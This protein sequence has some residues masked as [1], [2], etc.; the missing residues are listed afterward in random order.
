M[1]NYGVLK[2]RAQKF[3]RDND[4]DPH[5]ELLVDGGGTMYRIAVNVRSSRGPAATRLVEYLI[6][7]NV[8]HVIVEQA[9]LLPIGWSDLRDGVDDAAA[10]D[11]I[12]SNIFRANQMV[13][14][15]HDKPGPGNDLFEKLEDLFER[16]IE[17]AAAVVYAFGERWGPET[18]PDDYFG[19]V[20][21]NG[22]HDIHM[23]QGDSREQNAR[24][25]DGALLVEFPGAQITTG[26]FIKFQTQAWHTDENTGDPLPG[27]P[28]V[29]P[30]VVP[31]QGPIK[32]WDPVP[33]DSPYRV[34]RIVGAW[35]SP[36][37]DDLGKESVTVCNTSSRPLIVDGWSILD[38][39]DNAERISGE[40]ALGE[41][42]TFVLTGKAARLSNKGGTITL[43][44]E[45]GLKVDGVAY[46]RA[47]AEQDGAAIAF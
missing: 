35:V 43:L 13:P 32:P 4:S 29:P 12:R 18:K 21:G 16:A 37:R 1:E 10:I 9:R 27:T 41:A 33:S 25:Q 36:K 15:V 3:V 19:F 40:I 17:D 14:L 42:R 26:L 44:D 34:A 30:I 39:H 46:T 8:R 20:P 11:Y 38:M 5:A 2:G 47:D 23:N 7:D 45:R 6:L 28:T 22:V 31:P 24:F